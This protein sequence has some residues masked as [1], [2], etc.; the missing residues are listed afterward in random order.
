MFDSI[1]SNC[2]MYKNSLE[3]KKIKGSILAVI[4]LYQPDKSLLNRNVNAFIN[5]VDKLLIWD[6]TPKTIARG[7]LIEGIYEDKIIYKGVGKNVGISRVLNYAWRF[8]IN[9]GYDFLLTMDQDSVWYDFAMF[10]D[11]VIKKNEDEFCICGPCAYTDLHNRPEKSGFESFRWQI[12]SGMLIK[13]ELLNRIG[14]YNESFIVDCVDIELCLRAKSKGFNSYYCYDGFLLQKYGIPS[15]TKFLGKER[16][17]TYYNPF[18]VRGIVGGHIILY[19]IYKHPDL[20]KEIRRFTKEALKS[21][22]YSGK[23]PV[24]LTFALI[25]GVIDGFFKKIY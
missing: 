17:Y 16:R 24:G 10:K 25:Q 7:E 15:K 12:T 4:I 6:N 21:I 8:A 3:K 20:P 9:E 18:R 22:V 5:H 14:G 11:S 2:N 1:N 23:Q 13:T 19:R